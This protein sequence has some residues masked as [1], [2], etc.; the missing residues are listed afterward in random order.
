MKNRLF[1]LNNR[2]D[3]SAAGNSKSLDQ[4]GQVDAINKSQ[5][6]IHF[7]L[8]GTIIWANQNFLSTVGYS[9]DEV[10]GK[11]HSMFVDQSISSSHDYKQFW[12]KL[13]RGEY[14]A[15]KFKRLGKSGNEIWIQASYN[16]IMDKNGKPVKVVKFATDITEEVARTTDWEGKLSAISKSQAVIEFNLDGTIRT[17]NDNFLQTVGYSMSEIQ[18][19]PH[20]MFVGSELARSPEYREFW[21]SLRRGE[22]QA[23]EFERVGKGGNTIWIQASYNPIL[24]KNG[25]PV[26]VVKYAADITAQK[27][28]QL[29]IED[30][31]D[32]TLH[33][34]TAMSQGDLT[35]RMEGSFTGQFAVLKD[36]VNQCFEQLHA[37]LGKIASVA[38]NVSAESA[39]ISRGNSD[40]SE[41]TVEQAANLEET[42][43]SME[44]I[45]TTVQQN[46]ANADNANELAITASEQAKKGGRIVETAVDA[47]NDLNESSRK[48]SEIINVIND[49]A[50]QTNLLA[51]NASVESA[52]AGSEGR[53]FAVVA[54]E[55]RAL[56][57]R[58]AN[59]A[60]EIKELIEDSA[61]RVGESTDLVNKSGTSL[62]EIVA[63]IAE[64]TNIVGN[65]ATASK[66]QS[67]GISSANSAIGQIDSLT[68]QNAALVDQATAAG[69]NLNT[70]ALE[71]SKLVSSFK[72]TKDPQTDLKRAA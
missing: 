57:G 13:G 58:S 25:K 23:G 2:S 65:I 48:I 21:D 1:G 28:L 17:A 26:K 34:V 50:F 51:L 42:A 60:K 71:L 45:T 8:D 46:A 47:M 37:T 67:I 41:R 36:A 12:E 70:Q 52:R 72:L 39:E 43:S 49:I 18:G 69:T 10:K 19:Q 6:V 22:Y 32:K 3:D 5:A 16:P 33:A 14:V 4:A 68:Q 63:G 24:D 54:S 15:D 31:L 62:G 30:V 7:E 11:H 66:E 35:T 40:L 27:E 38:Q 64:V 61:Q 29:T 20:S 44:E 56:A 9:I 59:A 55:V 53:G